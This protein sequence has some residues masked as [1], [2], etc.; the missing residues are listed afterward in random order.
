MYNNR[1][2]A[3]ASEQTGR[4]KTASHLM[5]TRFHNNLDLQNIPSFFFVPNSTKTIST[6]VSILFSRLGMRSDDQNHVASVAGVKW[7]A[8]KWRSHCVGW[9]LIW[10]QQNLKIHISQFHAM[11]NPRCRQIRY[12]NTLC[13]TTVERSLECTNRAQL[14]NDWTICMA[15]WKCPYQCTVT[16]LLSIRVWAVL[17][18]NRTNWG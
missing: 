16:P 4:C 15:H 7:I 18:L 14:W 9:F 2:G 1:L 8:L 12:D 17:Q 13:F 10:I 6:S 11:C 5:T 3:R